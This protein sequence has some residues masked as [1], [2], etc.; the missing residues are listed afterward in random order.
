MKPNIFFTTQLRL[1]YSKFS[2]LLARFWKKNFYLYLTAL[3]TV[4]VVLDMLQLNIISGMRQKTFDAMVQYRIN[5][6]APD[7]EI[8]IV[9]INEASLE[10][11]SKDYGRWPWPRQVLGEFLEQL[12]KQQPKAIVFDIL[13]SDPDLYNPDSDAYFNDAIAAT[14][15]TFFPL[16]RLDPTS[17]HLSMLKPAMIPGVVPPQGNRKPKFALSGI[18][19]ELRAYKTPFN[20]INTVT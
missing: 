2:A 9:D 5:P 6:P 20:K 13:F 7:S 18:N 12:E 8:V 10:S 15:N 3:F 4:F 16:L 14:D 1:V 11:M 19:F 17:D